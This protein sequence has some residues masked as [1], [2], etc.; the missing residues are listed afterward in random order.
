MNNKQSIPPSRFVKYP[1]S[2]ILQKAEYEVIAQNIMKILKRTG[3]KFRRLTW[4]EYKAERLKDGNFSDTER[5][6]FNEVINYCKD[7]ESAQMFSK[8]WVI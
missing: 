8:E 1:W 7:A 4:I 6:F 2:S 3:D 5:V